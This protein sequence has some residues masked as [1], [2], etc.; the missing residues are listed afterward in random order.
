VQPVNEIAGSGEGVDAEASVPVR[1]FQSTVRGILS[2]VAPTTLVVGLLYY[3]GWARTSAEA[4]QLGLDDSLFGYSTQDYILRSISSMYWPLFIGAAALLIGLFVHGVVTA[5][6][7]AT[8]PG[9]SRVRAARIL[10]ATS[11]LLGSL[12]LVLGIV[13]AR[14]REPSRFVSLAAPIAVTASIVFLAYAAYLL[15][16]YE[17]RFNSSGA[18]LQARSLAP[19]AWSLIAA[20]LLLS[21]F[22]SVSHYAGV[23]GIDLAVEA[24]RRIASQPD[25]TIYSAQ[26][27]NL[28]QPVVENYIAGTDT[29]YHYVYSGLK[30]LFRSQNN[31]FL[32]P[33]DRSD[34][35]NIIIAESPTLRFEF[36]AEGP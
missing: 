27:L 18:A 2:L 6:L 22:W 30:L 32:R 24:E 3:F 21:L 9:T 26:R 17:P 11:A 35:R 16:R 5:G 4:H 7:D 33:A 15:A 25:V 20:L 28:Q 8:P 1:S 31:Y 10:W 36:S 29:A 14:D 13:G 19:A 23:R 12:L 34:P